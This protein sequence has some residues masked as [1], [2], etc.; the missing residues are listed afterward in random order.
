[1]IRAIIRWF[2]DVRKWLQ[3]PFLDY[4]DVDPLDVPVGLEDM[5]ELAGG[6]LEEPRFWR[7]GSFSDSIAAEL[8]R[9]QDLRR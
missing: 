1:M 5:H 2:A 6:K 3:E 7:G 4:D 8:E 9:E